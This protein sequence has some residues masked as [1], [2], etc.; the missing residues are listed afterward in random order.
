LG[1][2]DERGNT[3]LG[4]DSILR[5]LPVSLDPLQASYIDAIQLSVDF[6]DLTYQR[7]EKALGGL[8][9]SADRELRL[10][11]TALMDAWAMV[12]AVQRLRSLVNGMPRYKGRASSKSLFTRRTDGVKD[13]RN[14]FQHLVG[15]LPFLS[16]ADLPVLGALTW[17]AP[18][19]PNAGTMTVSTFISGQLRGV[20]PASAVTLPATVPERL[21][22]IELW[23]AEKS[24][25]LTKLYEAVADLVAA[26]EKAVLVAPADTP[27][28][29]FDTMASVTVQVAET[30]S[31]PPFPS[32][33]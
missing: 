16:R 33:T 21:G 11:P 19:D 4:K 22:Q 9:L 15:D 14:S 25:N 23:A 7:I 32:A 6:I 29:P 5:R 10:G 31:E 3:M 24:V 13:L 18:V 12:D 30:G 17:I 27:T 2:E 28:A 26:F 8:T 20:D 1:A